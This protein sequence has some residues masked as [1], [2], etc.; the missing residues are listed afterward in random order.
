MPDEEGINAATDRGRIERH[1]K[2]MIGSKRIS[3]VTRGDIQWLM[4]QIA[5]GTWIQINFPKDP[6]CNIAIGNHCFIGRRNF[7]S[8]GE[9]ITL[10]DYVLCGPNCHFLGAGHKTDNPFLPYT[11]AG[12]ENYGRIHIGVNC[13]LTSNVTITRGIEIGYGTI[14]GA[15]SR[16]TASLPPLCLAYGNPAVIT[17]LFDAQTKAWQTLP[18]ENAADLIAQHVAALP[19]EAE[20]LHVLNANTPQL[21]LSKHAAGRSAGEL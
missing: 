16:V 5:E 20:Y 13:W 21:F 2:P 8:V 1:I 14:V 10:S 12:I 3:T 7:F 18:K 19:T 15:N 6:T 9:G 11:A 4:R 17:K